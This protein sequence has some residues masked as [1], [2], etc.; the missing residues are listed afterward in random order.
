MVRVPDQG[1][2]ESFM[3]GTT[4]SEKIGS[5]IRWIEDSIKI[6]HRISLSDQ[7]DIPNPRSPLPRLYP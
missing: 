4:V 2:F 6:A 7:G 1:A 3:L 5:R